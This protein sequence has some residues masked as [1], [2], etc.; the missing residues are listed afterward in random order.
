MMKSL[1]YGISFSLG[2][3]CLLDIGVKQKLSLK[4]KTLS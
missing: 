4:E 3:K 1:K 2:L